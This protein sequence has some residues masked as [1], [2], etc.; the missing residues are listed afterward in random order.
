[1][2]KSTRNASS[3]AQNREQTFHLLNTTKPT[4]GCWGHPD[5]QRNQPLG[6]VN[7]TA[8]AFQLGK[9]PGGRKSVA[10]GRKSAA[11]HRSKERGEQNPAAQWLARDQL[12]SSDLLFTLQEELEAVENIRV[13]LR[14]A[15]EPCFMGCI[16]LAPGDGYLCPC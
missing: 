8:S 2:L 14:L 13:S 3:R 7:A 16:R 6:S 11:A 10:A 5:P 9:P 12:G 4:P 1:M 15:R